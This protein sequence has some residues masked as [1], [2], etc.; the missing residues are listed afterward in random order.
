VRATR[1]LAS[2]LP[3]FAQPDFVEQ[4][5]RRSDEPEGYQRERQ[6][7][8]KGATERERASRADQHEQTGRAIGDDPPSFSHVSADIVPKRTILSG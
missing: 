7:L 5:A 4:E 8:A 6:H 3:I 1:L 2:T